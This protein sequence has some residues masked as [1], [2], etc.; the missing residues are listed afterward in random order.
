MN[1]EVVDWK[2]IGTCNLRCLHCY[3]PP[4]TDTALPLEKLLAIIDKF[5]LLKIKWVV[6]TGGEPLLVQNIETVFR[7]LNQHNIKIALSTNTTYFR[8]FQPSIEKYVSSLNIPIDGSTP[9]IH[10]K[11]RKDTASYH[12]AADVLKFYLENPENKPELLRVGTVF[13]KA[14][15][16]DFINIARLLEPYESIISTWKIYE[17][18]NSDTHLD[19]RAPILHEHANFELEMEELHS[20]GLLSSKILVS[21]ASSRNKAYFMLNPQGQV[22]VPTNLDGISTDMPAGDFLWTPTDKLLARWQTMVSTENYNS[23]H[24]RHYGKIKLTPI[25]LEMKAR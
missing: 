6:L 15:Q 16:G 24:T 2:I 10:A 25:M 17:L 21:R 4:K 5:K 19:L 12:S 7:H 18:M 9:E 13:S 11:S 14:N 20:T 23:N 1:I 3:G 22:V 8:K